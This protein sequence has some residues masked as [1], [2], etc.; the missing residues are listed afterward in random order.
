M[1]GQR[2]GEL[3]RRKT[4]CPLGSCWETDGILTGRCREESL[5]KELSRGF[6]G[7]LVVKSPLCAAGENQFDSWSR[8]IPHAKEP[9]RHND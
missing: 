1:A 6:P 3:K 7:A 5:K 8:K 4:V 9:V 2:R